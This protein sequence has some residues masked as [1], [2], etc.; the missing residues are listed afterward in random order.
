M[1]LLEPM[2]PDVDDHSLL[3]GRKP[4]GGVAPC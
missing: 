2:L 3:T 4:G 1:L